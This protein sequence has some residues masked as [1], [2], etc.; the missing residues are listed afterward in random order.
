MW[1]EQKKYDMKDEFLINLTICYETTLQ[2]YQNGNE[3]SLSSLKNNQI[4][5]VQNFN[6]FI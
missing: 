2:F 6:L 5:D 1:F 3:E 4:T